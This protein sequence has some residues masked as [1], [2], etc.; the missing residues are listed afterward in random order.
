MPNW[1]TILGPERITKGLFWT[2]AWSLI[3][4]CTPVSPGCLHCW[5]ADMAY[6]FPHNYPPDLVN[7]ITH[8]NPGQDIR[9]G[10][11][12]FTGK[13]VTHP[14]RLQI[15]LKTR[16]SQVFAIWSDLFHE[17]VPLEFFQDAYV[18]MMESERLNLGHIFLLITKRPEHGIKIMRPKRPLTNLVL[19]VTAENQEQA[20][21][22]L[23]IVLQIPAAVRMILY[24]PALGP[25]NLTCFP[26]DH[27]AHYAGGCI[28]PLDGGWIPSLG[29]YEEEYKQIIEGDPLI[30][31]VIAG[32][33]TG[34]H[35]RPAHPDWFRQVRDNCAAAGVPFF[36]KSWGEWLPQ[37]LSFQPKKLVWVNKDGRVLPGKEDI[38]SGMGWK[39]MGAA[40][41]KKSRFLDGQEHN[42]LP[43][44][45][46]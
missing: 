35:A 30:H 9:K 33:E 40:G 28:N 10:P 6:R 16:K 11:A 27:P 42:D 13:V 1:P 45:G 3:S 24:E 5:L 38:R 21:K 37:E 7:K 15:P 14:E 32:A 39:M 34:H 2:K 23:P 17:K 46:D 26:Y 43:S 29:N 25:L 31:G 12:Y 20:D 44:I 4:G 18:I 8:V 19:I 41:K 22:R 36:F